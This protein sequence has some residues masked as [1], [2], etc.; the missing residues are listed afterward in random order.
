M[1]AWA[2]TLSRAQKLAARTPPH[3]ANVPRYQ[4]RLS[5][6]ADHALKAAFKPLRRDIA[7][8]A[9]GGY[10]RASR[11][12]HSDIDIV[13]LS[14]DEPPEAL[15]ATL[16]VLWDAGLRIGHS[17]HTPQSAAQAM[18]DDISIFTSLL[19]ARLITGSRSLMRRFVAARAQ[20]VSPAAAI[21]QI[22][23]LLLHRDARHQRDGE[24]RFLLEPHLK[25]SKGALRDIDTL[26]W[27][28]QVG[29]GED[30]LTRP[31]RRI[32]WNQSAA[33][34]FREAERFIQT[35]R[36]CLHFFYGR[37]EERLSFDAQ[38]RVARLMGYTGATNEACAQ[39]LMA[40][41]YA[42]TLSIAECTRTL[43]TMLDAHHLRT[44]PFSFA[45]PPP[46]AEG[47]AWQTGR[48][49]LH[50]KS[51]TPATILPLFAT[52][53][54][55]NRDIHPETMQWVQRSVRKLRHYFATAPEAAFPLRDI[56]LAPQPEQV[57]RRLQEAGVLGCI[58][59]E[60]DH[61]RAQMQ[62]DGYHTY[63]VD[64]HILLV[65]ANVH[66]LEQGDF[67]ADAPITTRA[68]RDLVNRRALYVAALCHDLAKGTGGHHQD[69]GVTIA[70]RV[71]LQLG[72]SD[73]EQELAGWLVKH[74]QHLS[75]TAFK[76]D[77]E[78]PRTIASL[79][80]IVQSPERLRLL[81]VLT[82]ADMRAV[83]PAI[84]NGWKASVLRRLFEKTIAAMGVKPVTE[85]LRATPLP[86]AMDAEEIRNIIHHGVRVRYAVNDA[87]SV[88][89]LEVMMP[90][91]RGLMCRCAGLIARMGANIASARCVM[92]DDPLCCLLFTLQN[93]R[94][95]A[96]SEMDR[97]GTLEAALQDPPPAALLAEQVR[98]QR[99]LAPH[100]PS[101]PV[102]SAIYADAHSSQQAAIIEV[103]AADRPGLLYDL[104]SVFEAQNLQVSGAY[105]ATYGT[106]VVDVFYVKDRFGFALRN[107]QALDA[108]QQALRAALGEG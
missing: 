96:F 97:L 90:Y 56:L 108:L 60:F 47:F 76:R 93:T 7:V 85:M 88:T 98:A 16:S 100:L 4:L 42:H 52:A 84:W 1:P 48:I 27:I 75:D 79:L 17:V 19:S 57:L 94:G 11:L 35:L 64:A 13:L 67:A 91:D 106:R 65:V 54:R 32:G 74:H 107:T 12:L 66:A 78:D 49:A 14:H 53:C 34:R 92:L 99:F 46:L 63:T 41:Y 102:P 39:Q 55:L 81:L 101:P 23:R 62:Y 2:Q 30:D 20:V 6:M 10:G 77:L 33:E 3:L 69:K 18:Q 31:H 95:E 38:L 43:C 68:A 26:R 24:M 59:P 105:I 61:V 5:R 21:R 8:V 104:L 89:E 70:M 25:N 44:P 50:S 58:I 37:S 72:L 40:A 28:F 15:R 29:F 80:D 82:V 71:A 36:A 83:G 86:Q 87:Q 45:D 51:R 103:N 22:D 9:V 73:A